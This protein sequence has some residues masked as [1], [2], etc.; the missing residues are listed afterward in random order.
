MI[1][2]WALVFVISVTIIETLIFVIVVVTTYNDTNEWYQYEADN[3]EI[4]F[5]FS[6]NKYNLERNNVM[7]TEFDVEFITPKIRFY[8]D[9]EEVT[10]EEFIDA[11]EAMKIIDAMEEIKNNDE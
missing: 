6:K 9:Y 8:V 4:S 7:S 11:L 2:N 3:K 5:V 10:L 1:A